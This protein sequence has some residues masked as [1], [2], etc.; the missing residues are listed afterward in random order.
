MAD[1]VLH[2]FAGAALSAGININLNNGFG[3]A[4]DDGVDSR[5]LTNFGIATATGWVSNRTEGFLEK[6]FDGVNLLGSGGTNYVIQLYQKIATSIVTSRATA[7][8]NT[9]R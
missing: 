9:Q 6:T 4:F 7:Q 1:Q 5:S 3:T 2:P 8:P